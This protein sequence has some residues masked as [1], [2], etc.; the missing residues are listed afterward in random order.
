MKSTF[1][2]SGKTEL[3]KNISTLKI[4]RKYKRIYNIDLTAF[5]GDLKEIQLY[6]CL[7]SGYEFFKPEHVAGDSAFYE[8]F[9]QFDWYYLPWKWEHEL[10][11]QR[12]KNGMSI[13][14]VGSGQGAFLENLL[15]KHNNVNCIGLELNETAEKKVGN[16]EI[17]NQTVESFSEMNSENFDLVCS[18]QVLEHIHDVHSFLTAKIKCLKPGGELIISVPN[19][20]AFIGE[21]N[22]EI[23]N[24]PPH[25]MGLWN[26][27]SLNYVT[28]LFGL[29][30]V[31]IIN[32]PLQPYH[33]NF[34]IRSKFEK[35]FGGLISKIAAKTISIIGLDNQIIKLFNLSKEPGH[36]IL[37]I[38]K[39]D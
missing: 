30:L 1:V 9:Q 26:S 18:Y 28:N 12:V 24:M 36:S 29:K 4:I 34:Y 17:I 3:V 23:L 37:A 32:E 25:H 19:N 15:K 21:L 11:F 31:E 13:L 5:F 7:T 6:R 14:E 35:I 2:P 22:H 20:G 39:K 16:L 8:H 27:K 10:T 33:Y 38:Y